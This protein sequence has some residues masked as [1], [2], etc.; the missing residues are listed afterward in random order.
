MSLRV[1]LHAPIELEKPLVDGCRPGTYSNKHTMNL[2]NPLH[3]A[4]ILQLLVTIG[5][6]AMGSNPYTVTH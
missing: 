5:F 1:V 3:G 4:C 2:Y 6:R